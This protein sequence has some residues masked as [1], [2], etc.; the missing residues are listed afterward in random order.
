MKICLAVHCFLPEHFY[1][2]EAYTHQLARH[3]L[4][5]G[6]DVVVLTANFVGEPTLPTPIQRYLVDGIRVVRLDKNR[7][8]HHCVAETYLQPSM[9]PILREVME[10]E[11][12]DLLHVTHLINL[13]ASLL[14]VARDLGIPAVA[15]MT[16]FF[17]FCYTNRLEDVK[18]DLCA[19][20]SPSRSNCLAC[21]LGA[22]WLHGS[23]LPAVLTQPLRWLIPPL[24]AGLMRARSLPEP[25]VRRLE[26]LR[27]GLR[28]RPGALTERYRHYR[29]VITPTRFLAKAYRAN[30]LATPMVA[31]WFGVDIDRAAKP[32]RP[33][34]VPLRIGYIG[35]LAEHKGVDLLVRAFRQLP[36]GG[37]ELVLYGSLDQ[38]PTYGARLQRLSRGRAVRFV[39]T[40][41]QKALAAALAELD[42]LV[43]PSRWYENSPL[44]LLS[45]LAC[46]T[47][48]IVADVEGMTEFLREGVN[49]F[50]FRRG[51]WRDLGRVLRRFLDRPGLAAELSRTTEFRRTTAAMAHDVVT[52]YE[53]VL[54]EDA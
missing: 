46:H 6:H 34:G 47:P 4:G 48:V 35:Q 28:E 44:V 5:W 9:A 16:D 21:Y 53:R 32:S 19:G 27:R 23:R 31:S 50:H 40:F 8:P 33:P 41:P 43:V 20:P 45:A 42:V 51:S 3:L 26:P 52:L 13:T 11:R 37:A 24:A 10:A 17:G 30:G 1:G 38:S 14:D 22:R 18:G 7:L 54:N 2:T 12:P 29:A 39:G 49:G 36:P 15:T 25:L